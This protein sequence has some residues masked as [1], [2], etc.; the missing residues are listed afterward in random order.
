MAIVHQR[1][2]ARNIFERAEFR[3]CYR[4]IAALSTSPARSFNE[5]Q[6]HA[7]VW[8]ADGYLPAYLRR[9]AA[10]LR[11]RH[12]LAHAVDGTRSAERRAHRRRASPA[13]HFHALHSGERAGAG[14]RHVAALL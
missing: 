5:R 3:N 11:R 2:I 10:A 4:W 13:D 7:S 9:H 14:Q 12:G 8:P 6:E 1:G